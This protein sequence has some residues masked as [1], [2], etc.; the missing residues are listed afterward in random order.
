MRAPDYLSCPEEASASKLAQ[1]GF[2]FLWAVLS[3]LFS[4]SGLSCPVC[5]A[6]E[7]CPLLSCLFSPSGQS[8]PVSLAPE[9][10]WYPLAAQ[11]NFLGGYKGPGCSG[12]AEATATRDHLPWP[13]ELPAP[14]WPPSVCSALE[15]PSCV[16]IFVRAVQLIELDS[17]AHLVSKAG[18]V[19]GTKSPSPV[20]KLSG[21]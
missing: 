5:L 19:I 2:L 10:S 16:C 1:E 17:H 4:P 12:R 11:W 15:A 9:G 3:C 6:P 13:P 7:G 21:S 14:P 20:F 18:S 8:C